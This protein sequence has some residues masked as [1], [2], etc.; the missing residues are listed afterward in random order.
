MIKGLVERGSNEACFGVEAFGPAGFLV[1]L[2]E[3]R[4]LEQNSVWRK[5]SSL[6]DSFLVG[7]LV[8]VGLMENFV[9]ERD[10]VVSGDGAR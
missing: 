8:A 2:L 3:R 10:D 9:H 6:G 4:V 7:G 5:S 1:V